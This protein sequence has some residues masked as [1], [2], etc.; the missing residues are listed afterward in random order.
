MIYNIFTY[1]FS[2][3]QINLNSQYLFKAI[4]SHLIENRIF[5]RFFFFE[6]SKP[7][8]FFPSFKRIVEYTADEH[9]GF[10]AVVRREPTDIKLIKKVYEPELV[11]HVAPVKYYAPQPEPAIIAATPKYVQPVHQK[12]VAP[13]VKTYT[14]PQYPVPQYYAPPEHPK[15]FKPVEK[16]TKYVKPAYEYEPHHTAVKYV[17]PAPHYHHY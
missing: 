12:I 2:R 1:H 3:V 16:V 5:Y 4:L 7:N 9:N 10:N 6:F 8:S 13:I 14:A 11:K 15:F 17:T